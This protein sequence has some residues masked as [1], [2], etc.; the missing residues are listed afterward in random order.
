MK[1]VLLGSLEV[2]DYTRSSF[3]SARKM[4]VVLASLLIRFRQTV[5][6]DELGDEIWGAR[7]PRR[8]TAALHVHVSQ[9]RKFLREVTDGREPLVTRSPGYVLLPGPEDEVDSIVLQRFLTRGRRALRLQ[10]YESASAEFGGALELFRGPVLQNLRGGPIVDE[11]ASWAEEARLEAVER[12]NDADLALG[13]HRE[14]VGGLYRLVA[15]HPLREA[16]HRQLML[17]LYRSER[18]SDALLAYRRAQEVLDRELGVRPGRALREL[19]RAV[20]AADDGLE[21]GPAAA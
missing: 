4:E 9:L 20:L 3:I 8:R 1:Y 18:Q 13:R 16:F 21:L 17:A 11:F 10:R 12:K 19:H 14:L 2:R 5:S 7:P 15:E 6:V